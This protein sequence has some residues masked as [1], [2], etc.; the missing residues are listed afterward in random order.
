MWGIEKGCF[1]NILFQVSDVYI[2][3]TTK[4]QIPNTKCGNIPSPNT[5]IKLPKSLITFLCG[6]RFNANKPGSAR[7]TFNYRATRN[8]NIE[9]IK[10]SLWSA[11]HRIHM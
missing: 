2:L 8:P 7:F 9:V 4:W 3:F 11:G 1:T 10:V 5:L 6:D